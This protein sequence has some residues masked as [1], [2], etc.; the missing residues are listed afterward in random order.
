MNEEQ[1]TDQLLEMLGKLEGLFDDG[2]VCES[3]S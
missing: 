1:A 2:V 3:E